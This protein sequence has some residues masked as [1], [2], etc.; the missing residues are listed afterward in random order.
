MLACFALRGGRVRRESPLGELARCWHHAWLTQRLDE[1][2]DRAGG[3]AAHL[4]MRQQGNAVRAWSFRSLRTGRHG[5]LDDIQH[6]EHGG[7]EN[8][9]TRAAVEQEQSDF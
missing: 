1:V 7:R 2:V 8:I 9:E 6:T 4:G 5:C 3:L